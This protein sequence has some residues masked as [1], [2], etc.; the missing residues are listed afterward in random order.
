SQQLFFKEK[1][2]E[3]EE[4]HARQGDSIYLLQPQLKEGLG[5][6]RDLHTALWMAKVKFKVHGFRDLVALGVLGER[7]VAGMDAALD[8]LWRVRNAM[9][10]VTASHQ[11]HLTFD[12]QDVLAPQLGFGRGRVGT[13]AFMRRYYTEAPTVHRLG[14]AVIARCVQVAEPVRYTAPPVR[15]IRDGMRIQ[16]TLLSVTGREV[17]DADP[18]AMVEVFVEAQRHGARRSPATVGL[19]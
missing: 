13:E 14:E 2:K 4:R 17:F 19:L 3:S 12:L 9:H 6:L 18:A 15:T 11:D 5:G 8:F 16:G 10:F 7:D 1:L